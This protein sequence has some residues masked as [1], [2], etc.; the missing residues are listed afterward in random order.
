MANS[1]KHSL[2]ARHEA[3]TPD[4]RRGHPSFHKSMVITILACPSPQICTEYGDRSYSLDKAD[5]VTRS[6]LNIKI[7]ET[8]R[9]IS[10]VPLLLPSS[11][12]PSSGTSLS[13]LTCIPTGMRLPMPTSIKVS[14]VERRE[15]WTT[16]R[17]QATFG[18]GLD[19][20]DR[21]CSV[22]VLL[23]VGRRLLTKTLEWQMELMMACNHGR[24]RWRSAPALRNSRERNRTL[25][26]ARNCRLR[27]SL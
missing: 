5:N 2:V 1:G 11:L 17:L 3:G 20:S 27:S 25:C 14:K 9:E 8:E 22:A 18:L 13:P 6:R 4:I 15:E 19:H 26:P 16:P 7:A 23:S 12:L 21:I 24:C 10:Y